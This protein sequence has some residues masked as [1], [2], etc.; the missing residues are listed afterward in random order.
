[1]IDP[2]F[3]E[4]ENSHQMLDLGNYSVLFKRKE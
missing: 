2:I 1:M 3:L 4:K